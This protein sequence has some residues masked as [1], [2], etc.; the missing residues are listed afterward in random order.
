MDPRVLRNPI[1]AVEAELHEAMLAS[2]VAELRHLTEACLLVTTDDSTVAAKLADVDLHRTGRL[3]LT[4]L[5]PSGLVV[6]FHD[7]IAVVS[8]TMDAAGT[9]DSAP[10]SEVYRCVRM[11]RRY[12]KGWRVV[13]EHISPIAA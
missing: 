3:R 13:V 12:R 2:D 8:V 4:K 10:F 6:R 7:S 11:W 1:A 9:L 5:E